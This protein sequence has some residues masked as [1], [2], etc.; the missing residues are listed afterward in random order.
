MVVEY[1]SDITGARAWGMDYCPDAIEIAAARTRNKRERLTYQVGNLDFLDFPEHFFDAI[2]S[3]DSLYMPNNLEDTLQ[4]MT[5]LLKAGG[6]IATFYI[7]MAWGDGADRAT[8]LPEKTPLGETLRK[9]GLAFE[10]RDYSRQTYQ[11]M[12]LKRKFG[13]EMKPDFE[14]EG[15]FSLYEFIINESESSV[16]PY[17]PDTCNFSRYLYQIKLV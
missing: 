2:I 5:R 15:N 6:Q 8:L 16:E 11:L 9:M 13:Q 12:Q 17:D 7:Q 3:I 14:A 4:K 1:I 10:T